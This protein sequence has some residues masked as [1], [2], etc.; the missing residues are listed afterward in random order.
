M[1]RFPFTA[2]MV[3]LGRDGVGVGTISVAVGNLDVTLTWRD[4]ALR[5]SVEVGSISCAV[6]NAVG[7]SNLAAHA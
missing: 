5:T 2:V 6:G 3:T 7:V 4:G 1:K